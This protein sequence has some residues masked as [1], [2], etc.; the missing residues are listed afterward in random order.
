M[1]GEAMMLPSARRRS[2]LRAR[3]RGEPAIVD[4][5]C[6]ERPARSQV[7]APARV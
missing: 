3:L 2:C 7:L 1:Y 4:L 6:G 5:V